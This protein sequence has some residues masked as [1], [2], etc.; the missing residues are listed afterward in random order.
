MNICDPKKEYKT[1]RNL[2]YSCQYHVIFT[3][4]Y[5]RKIFTPPIDKSLK[6]IFK[7]VADKFDFEILEQEVMP[8]H[9]HLLLSVNPNLGISSVVSKLKSFSARELKKQYP[10]LKKRLPCLWTNS[11]FVSTVGSVSLGV[12]KAYIENQKNV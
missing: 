12:V 1:T 9:V 8:D 4:K 11:K 10:H 5:R 6:Q 7:K 3:P 2:V